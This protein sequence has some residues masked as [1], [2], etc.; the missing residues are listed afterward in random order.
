MIIIQLQGGLGNQMFQFAFASVLA[1]NNKALVLIDKKLFKLNGT[2]DVCTPRNFE[3]AIFNNAYNEASSP[4]IISFHHLTNL[5]KLKRKCSLNYPKIYIEPYFGF[6]KKALDLRS[7]VY[8]NG[9][10]QSYKY[11]IGNEKFIKK[12]F[13]FP[14]EE[15]DLQNKNILSII[16]KSNTISVHIRRGDYVNDK[17]TQQF[18]GNCALGYYLDAISLLASQY[19][20]FTLL[21]FSD[22]SD[23]VKEQFEYLPYPKLFIDHN[24][25]ENSWKDMCLMSFCSHNIIANSTFSWWAAWLNDNPTK[26]VIAPKLWF[27]NVEKKA[28]DLIPPEWILI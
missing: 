19:K 7:P 17:I 4:N 12:I 14:I 26:V 16:E 22:D 23:W 5:N 8:I 13:S 2:R 11:F 9:Y 18:H 24:K 27:A 1:K 10:F 15:L 20:T 21:F 3:L 28:N 25:N 6:Y